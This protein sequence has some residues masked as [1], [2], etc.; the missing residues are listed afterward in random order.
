[1]T[2]DLRRVEDALLLTK[3]VLDLAYLWSASSNAVQLQVYATLIF[4]G[5]L[6]QVCQ[7]LATVLQQPLEKI[8]VE[9]VFR[10]LYYYST[11]MQRGESQSLVPFLVENA[12][13]LGLVKNERKRHR[14]RDERTALIW[15]S[16]LS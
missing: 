8:S 9:M 5:V 16:C 14:E 7:Q 10:G 11:A 12:K 1:M 6:I 2:S 3:R 13:L 15:G 4:Y